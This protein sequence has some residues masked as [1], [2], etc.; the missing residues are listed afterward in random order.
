[1]DLWMKIA[2]ALLMG[3][4]LVFLF[5]R[6]KQMLREGRKGSS[7]EWMSA[8]IPLAMVVGFVILLMAMM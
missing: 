8:L 1:M 3:M 6:A 2:S 7:Q 4:M 5:P